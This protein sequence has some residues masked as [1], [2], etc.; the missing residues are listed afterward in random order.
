MKPAGSASSAV[1]R[2]DLKVITGRGVARRRL[3]S[4]PAEVAYVIRALYGISQLHQ[5][6]NQRQTSEQRR[7]LRWQVDHEPRRRPLPLQTILQ[8]SHRKAAE[9][10]SADTAHTRAAK[11]TLHAAGL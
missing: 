9:Q 6:L 4:K 7:Y 8:S 1:E 3:R 10:R 5:P 2:K 11:S